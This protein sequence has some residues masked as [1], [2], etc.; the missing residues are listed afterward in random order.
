MSTSSASDNVF[1]Y[2][3]FIPQ[4]IKGKFTFTGQCRDFDSKTGFDIGVHTRNFIV[5]TP[6]MRLETDFNYFGWQIYHDI[7]TNADGDEGDSGPHYIFRP[8]KTKTGHDYAYVRLAYYHNGSSATERGWASSADGVG[9]LIGM[10]GA[11]T[12]TWEPDF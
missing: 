12:L 6:E 2:A 11:F 7:D 5:H 4:S 3:D 10:E 9:M 8:D 1:I